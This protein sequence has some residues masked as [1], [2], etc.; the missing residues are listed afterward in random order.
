MKI[1]QDLPKTGVLQRTRVPRE[2]TG[3]RIIVFFPPLEYESQGVR[4]I[5]HCGKHHSVIQG[6]FR[7][8]ISPPSIVS[9]INTS[10]FLSAA[11]FI[12]D[13]LD[14][15]I[16]SVVDSHVEIFY[17]LCLEK[18]EFSLL[19]QKL[20]KYVM[21]F[22]KHRTDGLNIYT[23][24]VISSTDIFQGF[25][26]FRLNLGIEFFHMSILKHSICVKRVS[27]VNTIDL[28]ISP[29]YQEIAGC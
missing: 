6:G 12:E 20:E 24:M 22:Y 7:V 10:R 3:G 21:N 1:N 17:I 16:S 2:R 4:I 11:E 9:L 25:I 23:Y 26:F 29:R 15:I 5:I 14:E 19:H 18:K 28:N 8:R 27:T 13:F